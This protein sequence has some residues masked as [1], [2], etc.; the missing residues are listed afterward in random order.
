[1]GV[2][3]AR[4]LRYRKRLSQNIYHIFL[5]S[6]EIS[7]FYSSLYF[8]YNTLRNLYLFVHNFKWLFLYLK[9]LLLKALSLGCQ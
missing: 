4:F 5:N 2:I 6:F 9:L 7:F 1:M 8:V 3:F